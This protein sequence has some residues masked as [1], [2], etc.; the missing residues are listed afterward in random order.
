MAIAVKVISKYVD[1][2]PLRYILALMKWVQKC[3]VSEFEIKDYLVQP[4][5]Y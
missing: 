4:I 3:K 2:L 1:S 5:I